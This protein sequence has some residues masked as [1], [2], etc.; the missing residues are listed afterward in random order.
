[1]PAPATLPETSPTDLRAVTMRPTRGPAERRRWDALMAAHHY[2]PGRRR[3]M[4]LKRSRQE[5]QS[6]KVSRETVYVVTSLGPEQADAKRLMALVRGHWTIENPWHHVRD[7]TYDEDRCRV[8]A[9]ELPQNL[10]SLTNVAIALIRRTGRFRSIAEANRHYAATVHE[11]A[12]AVL[13]AG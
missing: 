12:A 7:W 10:A 11:T 8:A 2:L 3:G 4:R 13:H 6:G 1:M 5:V 9:G